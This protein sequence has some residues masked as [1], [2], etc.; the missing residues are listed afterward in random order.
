M[1]NSQNDIVITATAQTKEAEKNI[2]ALDAKVQAMGKGSAGLDKLNNSLKRSGDV[3]RQSALDIRNMAGNYKALTGNITGAVT[4]LGLLGLAFAG[5]TAAMKKADQAQKEYIANLEKAGK[6]SESLVNSRKT[7]VDSS[8]SQLEQF[9]EL[10]QNG[11]LSTDEINQELLLVNKIREQWGDVGIEIDKA[12]GKVTGLKTATAKIEES[13]QTKLLEPLQ[14]QLKAAEEKLTQAQNALA[15]VEATQ[16]SSVA[17]SAANWWTTLGNA[18]NAAKNGLF[19]WKNPVELFNK[20]QTNAASGRLEGATA[21]VTTA[22]NEVNDLK[23]KIK[24]IENQSNAG[25]YIQQAQA[26]QAA[27][28]S[29]AKND[30]QEQRLIRELAKAQATGGDVTGA[31]TALDD[32]IAEKNRK[33]YDELAKVSQSDNAAIETAQKAYEHANKTGDG[34]AIAEAAKALARVTETAKQHTDEMAKIASG[35]YKPADAAPTSIART[36]AM[37]TFNAFGIGGLMSGSVEKEQLEVQK[38]IARNTKRLAM[39]VVSE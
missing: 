20:Y 12:T 6:A 3:S 39:P 38:E 15:T 16:A 34:A 14:K 7:L 25:L 13:N 37:G 1:A 4:K 9:N 36:T 21:D 24:D 22:K 10:A 31:R 35:L 32:Y 8:I 2:Q 28:A 17:D 30:Y 29:I 19:Q 11:S 33:R 26:R 5:V 27:E 18:G 23:A